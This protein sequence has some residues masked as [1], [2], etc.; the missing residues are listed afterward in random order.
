MKLLSVGDRSPRDHG[1]SLK[2]ATSMAHVSLMA[3]HPQGESAQHRY[4][5]T[6]F[7]DLDL[8]TRGPS[9]QLR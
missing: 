7:S 8:H 9:R 4:L 5:I 2:M 6:V 3:I 1:A